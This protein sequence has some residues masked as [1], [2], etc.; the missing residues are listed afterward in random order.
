MT[1][2]DL[3]ECILYLASKHGFRSAMCHTLGVG[4]WAL[5]VSG[6]GALEGVL[7]EHDLRDY[8]PTWCVVTV[9][10]Y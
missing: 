5:E 3:L 8:L 7:L 9:L 4:S 6:A 10:V 2:T 1:T